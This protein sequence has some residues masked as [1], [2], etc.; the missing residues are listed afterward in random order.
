MQSSNDDNETVGLMEI[1]AIAM[2]KMDNLTLKST[3]HF[4]KSQSA[5]SI[6]SMPM[7]ASLG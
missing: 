7:E 3:S 5:A 2:T 4:F 1:D 6:A